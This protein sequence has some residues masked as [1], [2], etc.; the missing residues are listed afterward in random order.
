VRRQPGL[1]HDFGPPRKFGG[2]L[3]GKRL[4]RSRF[5]LCTVALETFDHLRV[6]LAD[7]AW[8][9]LSQ[10]HWG[11]A[12]RCT[13]WTGRITRSMCDRIGDVVSPK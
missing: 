4:R 3:A 13:W 8:S 2:D 11:S 6:A 5:D 9:R 1:I 7:L 12:P 10:S